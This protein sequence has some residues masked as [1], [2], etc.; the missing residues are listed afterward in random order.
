MEFS[1]SGTATATQDLSYICD[2]HCSLW[3][4]WVL[5]PLS[6]TRVKLASSQ[7]QHQVLN[8]LSHDGN[9]WMVLFKRINFMVC[10]LYFNKKSHPPGNAS[11]VPTTGSLILHMKL[12]M[13]TGVTES[14]SIQVKSLCLFPKI[15][16][17]V[18]WVCL[19]G[20]ITWEFP[21]WHSANG[22]D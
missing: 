5:N 4:R 17:L 9:S 1:R 11:H 6:E 14:F 22:S 10:E 7:R 15:T 16:N 18:F 13:L 2:L 21:V 12:Q 19:I 3:Q 20:R 8:L